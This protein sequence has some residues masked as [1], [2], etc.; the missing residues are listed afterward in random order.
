[1]RVVLVAGSEW[2]RE[3][4]ATLQRLVVGLLEAQVW[5]VQLLPH[6]LVE[7]GGGLGVSGEVFPFA[8]SSWAYFRRR[9]LE[10]SAETLRPV[11]PDLVHALDESVW[12]GAV[13]MGR[14]LGVP[15]VCSAWA[16]DAAER[17]LAEDGSAVA[18]TAPTP[19]LTE[20]VRARLPSEAL[21]ECV[22]PGV[23]SRGE[24][25]SVAYLVVGDG[26]L[27]TQY[28]ALLDGMAEARE[29]IPHAMYFFYAP[30]DDQHALWRAAAER[31]LLD[32]T[33]VVPVEPGTRELVVQADALVQPRAPGRFR[34]ILIAGLATGRPLL[35]RADPHI[36]PLQDAGKV[37]LVREAKATEWAASL[38]QLAIEPQRWRAVGEAGRRFVREAH[39][40]SGFVSG[41][42]DVYR[43][44]VGPEPIRFTPMR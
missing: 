13:A 12:S 14:R 31:R 6:P 37:G 26:R 36:D 2:L 23:Y 30:G 32:Q 44:A 1:M 34:P 38:E 42:L 10:R 5:P 4:W 3:E 35:T 8:D 21:C 27:D 15:A 25:L 7:L 39:T 43:R 20:G 16:A 24:P 11:R 28:R 29:R 40:V 19:T 22:P 41:V 17:A 18:Y 33:S 9:R